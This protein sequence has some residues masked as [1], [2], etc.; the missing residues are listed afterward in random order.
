VPGTS[1]VL[2]QHNETCR[3]QLRALS[4]SVQNLSRR[5]DAL[6]KRTPSLTRVYPGT[7]LLVA[8]GRSSDAFGGSSGGLWSDSDE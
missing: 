4:D 8:M 3:M 6:E 2:Q 5:I 1:K 7:E